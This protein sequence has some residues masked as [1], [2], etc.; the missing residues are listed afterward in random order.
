M[1]KAPMST[2]NHFL[3]LELGALPVSYIIHCRQ[4]TFLHHILHLDKSDPVKKS[5]NAQLLLPF[6]KNW[7]NEVV[8]L[9]QEYHL[10]NIDIENISKSSWKSKVKQSVSRKAFDYL[11]SSICEKSKTKHLQYESF[12]PQKYVLN[13]YHKPAS[14][15]FKLRSFS[16]DCKGNRKSSNPDR[17]CRLCNEAEETQA[18]IVNCSKVSNNSNA[19]NLE[20]VYTNNV[21][22]ADSDILEICRRVDVFNEL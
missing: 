8:P 9:L 20:K 10:N 16:V 14:I 17:T 6:E 19:V 11:K 5:Y 22:C 12:A 1:M 4:L 15:I 21:Q 13:Y 18:H 2:P 7:A 3:Y